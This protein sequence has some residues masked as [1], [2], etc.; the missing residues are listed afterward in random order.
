[1]LTRNCRLRFCFRVAALLGISSQLSGSNPFLDWVLG[2][3]TGRR[4]PLAHFVLA[5]GSF[6]AWHRSPVSSRTLGLTAE[7]SGRL[8]INVSVTGRFLAF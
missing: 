6:N 8:F 5:G 2:C 4:E 7:S 1:M 3:L